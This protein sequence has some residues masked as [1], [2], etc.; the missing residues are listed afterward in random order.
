[1]IID[2]VK[3]YVL[4]IVSNPSVVEVVKKDISDDFSEIII[5]ADPSDIGRLIGK[6]GNMINSLKTI[7]AGCKAKDKR[8][9]KTQVFSI[10]DR[11]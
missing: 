9:Y 1:M 4:L 2:F 3:E 5:Y 7:I 6:D 10:E 8:S 11:Q